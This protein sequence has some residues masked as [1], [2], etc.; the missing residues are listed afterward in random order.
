MDA[1]ISQLY[2]IVVRII[3]SSRNERTVRKFKQI[4]KFIINF[5][6]TQMKIQ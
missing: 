3:K 6:V 5:D 4:I 2:T 1:Q